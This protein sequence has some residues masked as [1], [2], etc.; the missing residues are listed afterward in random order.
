LLAASFAGSVASAA[1]AAEWAA[2]RC[3]EAP[4]PLAEQFDEVGLVDDFEAGLGPWKAFAGGQQAQSK[5]SLDAQTAQRG[6]RSLRVDYRFVGKPDI[7][8][9]EF[10]PSLPI[11]EPGQGIGFWLKWDG[12]PLS[13]K[14]RIKDASGETHQI[15]LPRTGGDGWQSTAAMLTAQAEP[16][17][18]D[19]NRRLDY[20]CAL[21]S[22]VADRPSR[23]YAGTGTLWIDRFATVRPVKP[24]GT[25][26]I[27]VGDKRL[28][29]VYRPNDSVALRAS[30]PGDGIQWVVRDF[31]Q[32]VV[33]QGD[34]PADATL[35]EF[36]LKRQGFYECELSLVRGCRRQ[37]VRQFR[38]AAI[39]EP[40]PDRRNELVGMCSHFRG[41]AYPLE[42]M[43][44]LVR[45][46]LNEFRDEI[47]WSSVE[48][49]KGTL[50]MP[51]YGEKLVARANELGLR[52]L[53]ICDYSNPLYDDGGFPNSD[54]AVAGYAGY[55]AALAL[56]LR[57]KVDQ[58][59]IWNEWTIGCGM[60]GRPGRNTPEAYAKMI[61][62]A[63]PAVK[64]VNAQ[65]TVVG[66]GGEHSE[67][68]FENIRGMMQRGGRSMDVFSVHGYRYPRSPEESDLVGEIE[69][70]SEM[71][72]AEGGPRKIWLTEIGW[73]THLD[74][75]GVDERTQARY[76]VRTM[77]LLAST[78]VVEKM[79]WYDFK[80]DGLDRSYNEN[81]FGIVLY[82][83][84]NYAPKPAAAAA[85]VF[86][87]ATAGARPLELWQQGGSCAVYYELPDGRRLAV[88][89]Q[90]EGRADV[91]L[92]G[93]NVQAVDLM[94]NP[95]PPSDRLTLTE[96]PMYV[97]G[98]DLQI[99]INR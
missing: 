32:T 12:P 94:G 40:N 75:R 25:L 54:E 58:F 92:T 28:G 30:G 66:I 87:R 3:P 64:A 48:S 2:I 86:S 34:G 42:C 24:D 16:W 84:F 29:N 79:H 22:I 31:W 76:F 77:A 80:D 11:A 98:T 78:G 63:Y 68:H 53:L 23:G 44:L 50:A 46:G 36:P 61:N 85:A 83:A 41:N 99:E 4:R 20:P 27:E 35:V 57:G 59:E 14:L 8:Y 15:S 70:V 90:P 91:Q 56:M 49:H 39:A 10:G 13:L 21:Y 38:A 73:P 65:A 60:S 55:C 26:A 5:L 7:E 62:A 88:A 89:W 96:D 37:D 9:V 74:S 97:V 81:N 67:H 51:D 69:R 43:D 71:S 45:Y 95:L 17:G 19:G 82:Q 93:Q 47:S 6:R 72:V 52:P 18:G 33:A 1:S